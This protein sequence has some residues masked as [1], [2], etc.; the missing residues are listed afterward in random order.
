MVVSFWGNEGAFSTNRNY[1]AAAGI[2]EKNSK[3][4]VKKGKHS[5]DIYAQSGY[6]SF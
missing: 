4:R 2:L 5:L 3:L 6:Y 1:K